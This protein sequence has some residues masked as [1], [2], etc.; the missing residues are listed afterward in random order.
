MV[1]LNGH[2]SGIYFCHHDNKVCISAVSTFTFFPVVVV[3]VLTV[4]DV[5]FALDVVGILTPTVFTT[6]GS[7]GSVCGG[8]VVEVVVASAAVGGSA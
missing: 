1:E 2:A 4:V 3:I 6:V 5:I 7:N 8:I